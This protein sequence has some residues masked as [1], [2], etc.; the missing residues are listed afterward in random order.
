MVKKSSSWY[1]T[2]EEIEILIKHYNTK[3]LKYVSDLL[4]G[5]SNGAIDSQ[6]RL[7]REEGK[8]GRSM[9]KGA[10]KKRAP[11]KLSK[12]ASREEINRWTQRAIEQDK[13]NR[14]Y[15]IGKEK[16]KVNLNKDC[17]YQ[18]DRVNPPRKGASKL[19]DSFRCKLVQRTH[20][21]AT[22]ERSNG[23]RESFLI[24]D[25]LLNE[26]SIKELRE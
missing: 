9:E 11:R 5:R 14:D 17:W 21:H 15:G 19:Q 1:W 7:L 4:P 22:F 2:E 24:N 20:N 13:K 23:V 12:K 3:G 26:I 10:R 18:V 25:V 8:M 16:H 6:V